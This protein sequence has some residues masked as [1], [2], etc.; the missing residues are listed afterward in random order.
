L[1]RLAANPQI[2]KEGLEQVMP[3]VRAA[4]RLA[5]PI[6]KAILTDKLSQIGILSFSSS[7]IN[8]TLWAHYADNGRGFVFEFDASHAFFDRRRTQEDDLLLLR[9]VH[10]RNREGA[11]PSLGDIDGDDLF[12][13]KAL[14][15][16]YEAEW[17][18]VAPLDQATSKI[19]VNQEDIYLFEI[20]SSMLIRVIFGQKTDNGLI[21]KIKTI[22]NSRADLFHMEMAQIHVNVG[23]HRLDVCS[24]DSSVA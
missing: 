15:W 24:L 23:S 8:P 9:P 22:I 3:S 2:I 1:A 16:A 21:A 13:T 17:R 19:S 12:Y 10:Y 7:P 5:G 18:I 4:N 6:A 14:S 11:M 20:P